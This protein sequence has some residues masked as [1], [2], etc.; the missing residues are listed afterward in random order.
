KAL[1]LDSSNAEARSMLAVILFFYDWDPAA[2]EEEFRRAL[3]VNPNSMDAHNLYASTLCASKRWDDGLVE[4]ERAIAL[5]PL[6]AYPSWTREACLCLARRY[7][8]VLAQHKKTEELDPNFFSL[9]SWA[10]IAYREKKMYVEAAAEYEHV[11]QVNGGP[12]AGLAVTYAQ[13]GRTTEARKILQEFLELAGRRYVSPDQVA[14][15]YA[16]L[17][18]KDQAFAW[19]DKAYEARSGMA[20]LLITPAYDPLRADP[21]FTALL[22]KMGLPK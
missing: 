22:K 14:M 13:M 18:E 3:Q 2:S 5:D 12:V 16:S 9:D 1:E 6:S 8:E 19:L 20:T 7:D 15:I 10:G 11:R 17:G 21:R 4:A